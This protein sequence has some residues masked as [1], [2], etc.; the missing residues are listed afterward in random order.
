M[1]AMSAAELAFYW[2]DNLITLREALAAFVNALPHEGVVQVA[3]AVPTELV[4]PLERCL[5]DSLDGESFFFG[6]TPRVGP[7]PL[8]ASRSDRLAL[9]QA[10]RERLDGS[11]T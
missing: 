7:P 5:L 11:S 4:A 10:L 2:E 1:K 3:A 6:S 8:E 9:A